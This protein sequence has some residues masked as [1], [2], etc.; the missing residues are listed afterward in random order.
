VS[1]R[2]R[3][4]DGM[5]RPIQIAVDCIDPGRLAA[6]WADVLGYRVETPPGGYASWTAFSA[7]VGGP[8]EE[9]SAVVDPDGVGPRVLFHRVPEAKSGKNR[10]HMDVRVSGVDNIPAAAR[11]S[12]V[13][14]EVIRLQG[15]GAR[16]LRTVDDGMDYFAVLQDPEGNEF[17][18]N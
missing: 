5:V 7:A 18:I 2:C 8:G 6:F 14:A 11:H 3:I 12:M 10:V 1:Y 13:D 16:H 15:A 17:C 9:W 4:I